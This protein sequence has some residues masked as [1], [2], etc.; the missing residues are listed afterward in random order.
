MNKKEIGI[1]IHIPFCK[2]KCYYCDFVSFANCTNIKEYINQLKKEIKE[3]NLSQYNISTIYIGGGTPSCI[4]STY[5]VE[6][7]E[8]LNKEVAKEITIEINPGTVTKEKLQDYYNSG[9]NRLSIGLQSTNDELLK[10]IGRI[11]NFDTFMQTY[12]MARN[13]GFKN[14]NIDLM[15]GLPTQTITDVQDS[16]KKVIDLSPEHISVY[17]LIIEEG[18][19]LENM[20]SKG[21]LTIPT[22]E[23]ERNMYWKVKETLEQSG[24]N[25]YEISNFAKINY[26]SKHNLDC[27]HQM[28]YIGF[29]LAAHSYINNIRYSNTDNFKKYLENIEQNRIIQEVQN[30]ESKRKEYMLL[31]LRTLEGINIQ[32]FKNKFIDNPIYLYSK[33][34]NKLVKDKLIEVDDNYIKLT[35]RGIDLANLVW[36]EFV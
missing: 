7:L 10:K 13:I 23:T 12:K 34:L 36:E 5:I 11:H 35:N 18:T 15:I 8:I 31:G 32:K 26:Q 30:L 14:I 3:T 29:G 16:L 24:Y 2:Q 19:K 28:E 33:E 9:I 27:W 25:H 20:I 1:Y 21:I 17:S 22:E 4:D 6:I